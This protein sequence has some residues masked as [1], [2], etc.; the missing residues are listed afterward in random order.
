[1]MSIIFL[2]LVFPGPDTE[3]IVSGDRSFREQRYTEAISAYSRSIEQDRRNGE[4]YWRAVRAYICLGDISERALQKRYYRDAYDLSQKALLA[5]S[6]NSNVQCW[7]AVAMGYQA[8]EE[9]SRRK[10]ELCNSIKRSL[11]R[12]IELDP[13]NDVAYS[14]FGTFYRALGNI[15]WFEHQLADLLLGGLPPGGYAEAESMLLKAVRIAPNIIRHRYELGLVY[16]DIGQKEKGLKIFTEA[17]ALP[18]TLAS[19]HE[20]IL[21]MK[22]RLSL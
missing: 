4:A 5:D 21:D 8:L 16:F 11:E 3:L 14:I 17:L 13:N 2:L 9:G 22:K 18:M 20:R 10:V 1:M 19:D 6:M 12:A 7:Y 15:S